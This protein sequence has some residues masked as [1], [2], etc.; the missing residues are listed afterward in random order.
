MQAKVR[1]FFRRYTLAAPI[2]GSALLVIGGATVFW[3]LTRQTFTPG[4]LPVGANVI[5]QD[6]LVV[7]TVN[8]DEQQWRQLR[9]FGTPK[10]QSAFDQVLAQ[11]RDQIFAGNG[12]DYR[13]DIK[14]W[15]GEAVTIAQLS[16]QAELSGDDA[17]VLPSALSPQ[18]MLAILPIADPL[19]AKEIMSNPQDSAGRK[20]SERTHRD[21][22][23]RESQPLQ[24]AVIE[25]R[26]LLVTNSARSMDSAIATYRD[27]K[28]LAQTPG[29]AQALGQIQQPTRPFMTLYRNIPASITSAAANFDKPLSKSNQDWVQQSQG[30]ATV[31]NLQS[32]GI[33]LRN[34]AWLKPDSKRKIEAKNNAKTMTDRMPAETLTMFSGSDF[35]QFWQDYQRDYVT[36]P[37]QPL[38]PGMFNRSIQESLGLNW[39]DDL[40]NWMGGEFVLGVVPMPGNDAVKTPIGIV[41]MIQTND[42]AQAEVGL[43]KLDAAMA[44]RLKYK[45]EN[46]KFNN[47]EVTNWSDPNT[48]T[49]VTRGWMN[50]NVAFFAVGAPVTGTF[51]PQPREPLGKDSSFRQVI[52]Q[53]E[54]QTANGYFL[55]NFE[56]IFSLSKLPP[57]LTWMEPYR[58]WL[59][60]VRTIGLTAVNTSDRSTRYDAIVRLK[61]G[62]T[63]GLL[64]AVTT[65]A[66]KPTTSPKPTP[67]SN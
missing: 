51:F 17:T 37:M 58:D 44:S 30:W 18:P 50:N 43:K 66:P 5:P 3:W 49:T 14:P 48:G 23:I 56:R 26:F 9:Q 61:K 12:I 65:P 32:E 42:R 20:W 11:L 4:T 28:S 36:Y 2:A 33:E 45:V 8:T 10:S 34:V 31:A 47:E 41:A 40:L 6:A 22:K 52:V 27:G 1:K 15:V 46:G 35:K 57:P 64:P 24:L 54:K 53:D 39:D 62:N 29:Y 67:K 38:N 21:I 55:I 13:R 16:P 59:E 60:G 7:V 19:K 25:N 63:P